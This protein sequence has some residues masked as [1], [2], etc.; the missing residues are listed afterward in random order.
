MISCTFNQPLFERIEENRLRVIGVT[1]GPRPGVS[2]G[3]TVTATAYFAGNPVVKVDDFKI[4]NFL[5]WGTD[6]PIPDDEYPITPID[7]LKG[8]PD[9]V[10][11]SFVIKDDVFLGHKNYSG[12]PQ[13]TT[14]SI[15]SIFIKNKTDISSYLSGL[16]AKDLDSLG[17][18][19]NA[20]LL[21]ASLFLT[22]HAA[23]GNS[24]KIR[25]DMPIKYRVPLPGI[26][27]INNN[28]SV[29]WVGI[30]KV[31]RQYAYG[32]SLDAPDLKNKYTLTYLYNSDAPSIVDGIIDIDTGYSYFLAADNSIYSSVDSQGTV[33]SD[34]AWDTFID[35]NGNTQYETY[36][37]MWFYQNLDSANNDEDSLM[38][39]D[40]GKSPLIEMRPPLEPIMTHF[41]ICLCVYGIWNR[42]RGETVRMVNGVFRYSEAYKKLFQP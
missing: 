2:P 28:P 19:V 21:P 12:L 24:L 17:K 1:I 20:M 15:A 6:G 33:H 10:R 36:N 26:S 40:N 11:F 31:P 41:K 16:S 38:L 23:N 32:F 7:S 34:T 5:I 25:S 30:C 37:Y 35:K 29:H 27:P 42:P 9:S 13:T 14:D 3:D 22:A 39:I 8:L 18:M 4:A